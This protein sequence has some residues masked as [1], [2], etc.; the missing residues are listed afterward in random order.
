M[1]NDN[2]ALVTA[3]FHGFFLRD[4]IAAETEYCRNLLDLDLV[5]PAGVVMA[6][7]NTDEFAQIAFPI[8]CMYQAAFGRYG[9]TEELMV[10]RK[11]YDTGLSLTDMGRAFILS[12]EFSANNGAPSTAAEYLQAMA[13]VGLGVEL[14]LEYLAPL[15]AQIDSG[16][17]N[18]GDLL[19]QIAAVNGRALHVGLSMLYTGL[20][21]VVPSEATLTAFGTDVQVAV[22]TLVAQSNFFNVPAD[23]LTCEEDGG[24]LFLSG[25]LPG[26]LVLDL[27][28]HTLTVGGTARAL[29]RGSLTDIITTVD[30]TGIAGGGGTGSAVISFT[31]AARAET[32][33]ASPGGDVIRGG[34]GN[35][36][37][38]CGLGSDRFLFEATAA[39]NG[40]DTISGFTQGTGGDI[41]DFTAFIGQNWIGGVTAVDSDSTASK[42]WSNGDIL[43]V[44]G[45]GLT[46]ADSIAALFGV[47]VPFAAP[48]LRG[49][50]VVIT[51]DIVGDTSVWYVTNQTDTT[52]IT[53]DEVSLVATLEGV[54]V[55]G[56]GSD[57]GPD[58]LS[59]VEDAGLLVL[60]GELPG[61]LTLDLSLNTLTVGGNP[62]AL[63]RGSLLNGITSVDATGLDTAGAAASAVVSFIGSEGADVYAASAGGDIIRGGGGDDQLSGGLGSDRFVCEATAALN[64]VDTIIG[65]TKGTDGDILDFSAFLD[66]TG[67]SVSAVDAVDAEST[68]AS[69]WSNGDV[70]V[71]V[72]YDLTSADAV[73]AL[74]G[75][76]FA[77]AAPTARGKAVI[78]T[79]DIIG[80]ASVWYLVN[81]TDLTTVSA[82][83]LTLVATLVGVNNLGLVGFE[84]GNFV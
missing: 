56:G 65:F 34:G 30:A 31:G 37:L 45:N 61:S 72:G 32:Y 35:D 69:P 52:N 16:E 80:D 18:Y 53:A 64:G 59:C 26:S 14:S 81:Q 51:S 82:E 48:A 13:R 24:S 1:A 77:F 70:L 12:S 41:L 50:A 28:M 66:Q 3:L 20:E 27:S 57:V 75:D 25:T 73:A 15:G 68:A 58:G 23:G 10:W 29:D 74:F 76:G 38:T 4:P 6:G 36:L 40:A 43:V 49:K 62:R 54:T 78:I 67:T 7:L 60:A 2:A 63:D 39:L 5:T 55:F 46:T 83:E 42:P 8:A 47:A 19:L 79:S 9:T 11:M 22:S 71:A 44:A 33:D 84:T 21:G 17:L